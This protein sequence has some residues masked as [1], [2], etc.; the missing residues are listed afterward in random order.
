MIELKVSNEVECNL[1]Y[2]QRLRLAP[3]GQLVEQVAG[4]IE[5]HLHPILI[6]HQ[7]QG[8]HVFVTIYWIING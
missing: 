4:P 5:T 6:A 1:C 3:Q 8:Q 7:N 2:R